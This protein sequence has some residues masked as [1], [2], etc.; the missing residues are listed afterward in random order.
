MRVVWCGVVWCGANE[1]TKQRTREHGRFRSVPCYHTIPYHTVPCLTTVRYGTRTNN[2][3][4]ECNSGRRRTNGVVL[5]DTSWSCFVTAPHQI[6]PN[7]SSLDTACYILVRCG[8][9]DDS[10]TRG[11]ATQRTVI[12]P[13]GQRDARETIEMYYY[14]RRTTNDDNSNDRACH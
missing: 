12:A 10:L 7:H 14:Y 3:A 13:S 9:L 5:P 8:S 4:P 2:T 1:A 11:C 6:K